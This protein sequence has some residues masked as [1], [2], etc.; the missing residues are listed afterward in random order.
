MPPSI[1]I[2]Q[3]ATE[4]ESVVHAFRM[5]VPG[6]SL[7]AEGLEIHAGN[8]ICDAHDRA[9][10][11]DHAMAVIFDSRSSSARRDLLT[12]VGSV[13]PKLRPRFVVLTHSD[14]TVDEWRGTGLRIVD[15]ASALREIIALSEDDHGADDGAL[16]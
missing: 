4:Q 14:L 13:P 15:N 12:F 9:R 16:T 8:V 3:H 5:N 7:A 2:V 6:M 10:I 11:A 1:L